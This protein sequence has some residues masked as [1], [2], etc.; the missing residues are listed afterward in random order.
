MAIKKEK[1][2]KGTKP[3]EKKPEDEANLPT[4]G[5]EYIEAVGRRKEAVARV[6][7]TKDKPGLFINGKTSEEY[8]PLEKQRQKI[9]DPLRITN[10][11]NNFLISIKVKGG[12]ISGQAE[13]IRL[14]ISRCLVKTDEGKYK[15]MLREKGFLT[16]DSREV[17]RKKYGLKKA[18]KRAQWSKR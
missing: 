7:L 17:E 9:L 16:R 3:R 1:T 10:L 18:R 15:A 8:F 13:A 6:R 4:G 12:G 5:R 2:T 14:G 11:E